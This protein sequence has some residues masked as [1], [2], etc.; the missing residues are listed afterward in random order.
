MLREIAHF[1][2]HSPEAM[3]LQAKHSRAEFLDLVMTRAD[4]RGYGTVRRAVVGDLRGR[5]LE[6]G[7]GTGAM[8]DYYD[9]AANVVALEPEADFFELAARRAERFGKRIAVVDGNGMALVF[10]RD[11]FDAVVLGLVLCSVPSVEAVL[12]ETYRVV[13]PSGLLR[14]FEHVRSKN[15][16]AGLLMDAGNPLWLRLNKQGCNWN[17]DPLEAIA[18]VGF[19]VDDVQPFKTFETMLPAFPMVR[20]EAHKPQ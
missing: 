5:V 9:A 7:C 10:E 20:V 14:A 11:S 13:R 2:R 3:R 17:R 4:E 1:L 15:R 19:V 6:I 16:L 12:R 18:R 8:F